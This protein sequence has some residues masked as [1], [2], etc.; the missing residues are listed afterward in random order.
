MKN[1]AL[2]LDIIAKNRMR[3]SFIL[4]W[5]NIYTF[6][7]DIKSVELCFV[8]LESELQNYAA[9]LEDKSFLAIN[10]DGKYVLSDES[11]KCH[12]VLSGFLY[13]WARENG[14]R[15]K[16]KLIQ[17]LSD[18]NF[19]KLLKSLTIFK[20]DADDI[21]SL[22][23][24]WAHALQWYCIFT[25]HK[26]THFLMHFPVTVYQE[27]GYGI[28][29]ADMNL[30]HLMFDKVGA[31]DFTSPEFTTQFLLDNENRKKWPLLAECVERREKKLLEKFKTSSEYFAALKKKHGG[32]LEDGVVSKPLAS[33]KK[34]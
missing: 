4:D 26:E 1:R 29:Q 19:Y 22:H 3:P 2:V 31:S 7:Q 30:W 17:A 13:Q 20:D 33:Y 11:N 21:G 27:F 25:Q 8:Q 5:T 10:K 23:G 16:A 18:D 34:C 9:Q 15:R 12:K 28:N 24:A 32:E 14:F 6:L